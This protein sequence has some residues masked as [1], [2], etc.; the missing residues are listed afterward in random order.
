MLK[1]YVDTLYDFFQCRKVTVQVMH[2]HL[3]YTGLPTV[4]CTS[5]CTV[6]SVSVTC[7]VVLEQCFIFLK[8]QYLNVLSY[9]TAVVGYSY[10]NMFIELVI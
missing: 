3:Q 7:T 1:S 2:D 5:S 6:P 10:C 9:I 4:Y 8:L